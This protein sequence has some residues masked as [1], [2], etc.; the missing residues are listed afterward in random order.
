MDRVQSSF[1]ERATASL[2]LHLEKYGEATP[3][4]YDPAGL[5]VLLASSH[6]VLARKSQQAFATAAQNTATRMADLYQ[7]AFGLGPEHIRIAL[8]A[9]PQV[10]APV[11]LGRTIAL[12]LS[13]S[14]WKR[15]WFQK[16]GF[17]AYAARFQELIK[18]ETD[19]M[20][21]DLRDDLAI[22]L[23][24]TAIA[25]FDAFLTEQQSVFASLDQLRRAGPAQLEAYVA[26]SAPRERIE[27]L[28]RTTETFRGF[29]A[30]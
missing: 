9:V 12:D 10:P 6:Q 13:S 23:R 28:D 21:G 24:D 5:R 29:A 27:L 16:R 17:K 1:L 3:W 22:D 20:I 8:P 11:S 30:P 19:P 25:T 7:T 18:S 15:W 26:R 2:V 14:W 4:T